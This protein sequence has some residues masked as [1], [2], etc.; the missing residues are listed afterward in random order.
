MHCTAAGLDDSCSCQVTITPTHTPVSLVFVLLMRY[1]N[2]INLK[3][4]ILFKPKEHV[5]EEHWGVFPKF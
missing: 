2:W 3:L 5:F 4:K 1:G